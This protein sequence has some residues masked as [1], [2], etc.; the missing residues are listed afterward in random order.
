M[1]VQDV[2]DR[3]VRETVAARLPTYRRTVDLTD[4]VA[5]GSEG[6]GLDSVSLVELLL[7]CEAA[8]GVSFPAALFAD[9]PLTIGALVAHARRQSAARAIV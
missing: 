5:L 9:G 2:L 4:D 3:V 8:C 6:L 1:L 7:D